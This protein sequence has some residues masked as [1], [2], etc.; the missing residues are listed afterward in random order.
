MRCHQ[1]IS[2]G[3]KVVFSL[4]ETLEHVHDKLFVVIDQHSENSCHS[5]EYLVPLHVTYLEVLSLRNF[6]LE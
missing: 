4:D 2:L 3:H 5:K 1:M 6:N